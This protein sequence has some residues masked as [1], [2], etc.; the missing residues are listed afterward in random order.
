M[1]DPT[2]QAAAPQPAAPLSETDDKLWA[3]LAHFLN[4]ILLIPALIIYLV[5]G[6]RGA[7]TRVEGK[8]ALNWTINVTGAV[9]ILSILQLIPFIGL[10]FFLLYLAVI[11]VNI[12]FAIL[13]GVK[14]NAGGSYRY[15][16]NIR[17]IK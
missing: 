15:P 13:G 11:I 4:I 1:T 14:V 7:R 16:V 9:I 3:S 17:W 5:F 10:L 8:E 2:P 12:V 6:P